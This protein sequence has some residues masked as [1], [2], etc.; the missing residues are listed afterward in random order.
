[1]MMACFA[2]VNVQKFGIERS[3]EIYSTMIKKAEIALRFCDPNQEP[4]KFKMIELL[5]EQIKEQ[6]SSLLNKAAQ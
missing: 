5:I 6:K 2:R 1:M 3:M 4:S